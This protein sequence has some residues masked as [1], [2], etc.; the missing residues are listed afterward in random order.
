MSETRTRYKA[1]QKAPAGGSSSRTAESTGTTAAATTG[2]ASTSGAASPA[3]KKP[4]STKRAA[5]TAV[6]V[7]GIAQDIVRLCHEAGIV[8]FIVNTSGGDAAI[9]LGGVYYCETCH[10][11]SQGATCTH[12]HAS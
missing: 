7:L 5:P 11:L 8:A 2:S 3:P 6:Q 4:R 12:A 9:V 10:N 1:D